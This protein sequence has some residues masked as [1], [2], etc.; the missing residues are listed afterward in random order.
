MSIEGLRCDVPPR[1]EWWPV[2][3]RGQ[4]DPARVSDT[5]L[6]AYRSVD[7]GLVFLVN[8]KQGRA[9]YWSST[10]AGA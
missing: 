2:L 5:G 8:W 4:L 9:Y 3:L 1:I 6:A 7:G 10:H